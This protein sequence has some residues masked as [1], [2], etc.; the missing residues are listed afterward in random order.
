MGDLE[1]AEAVLSEGLRIASAADMPA[2]EARIRVALAE[3]HN[4]QSK[5]VGEALEECVTAAAVLES[6]GDLDG[7]AEAWLTIGIL[8]FY[9]GQ[10]PDDDEAL[11]R[12]AAYAR[13][14]GN[15][16]AE[17][18]SSWWLAVS[19]ALLR[20]PADAAITRL[21]R[22][23]EVVCGEPWAEAGVL[24]PLSC[25]Y[26][27]AGRFAEAREA[28]TR[29]QSMFAE[30]GAKL[31][32]ALAA[33][34]A[35]GLI[36]LIAGDP[37]GAEREVRRGYEALLAM[38]EQGYLASA[39]GMLAEALY[40]QGRFEEAQRLTEE[41]EARAADADIDAQIRWRSTRAKL[42]AHHGLFSAAGRLA[43]EAE[44]LVRRT[45]WAALLGEV[46]VAKAEVSRLAGAPEQAT[47]SLR[48]ALRLYEDR[49]ALPLAERIRT[50][51]AAYDSQR[52]TGHA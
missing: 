27:Y 30:L 41:A 44:A 46:L 20:M 10:S 9:S 29:S 13:Q 39:A 3:A 8:R 43:Y 24:L 14:S 28:V 40:A 51:L 6:A 52:S 38:S 47:R 35:G 15:R 11:V 36:E 16:R 22:L 48:T 5:G 32:C 21:E 25:L 37:A 7:L 12:A 19:L 23:L 34:H 50:M 31:N 45:P 4:A 17:L 26:G 2:A 18:L 42:L 33:T 1:R 49:R